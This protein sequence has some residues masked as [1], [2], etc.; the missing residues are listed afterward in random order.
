MKPLAAGG[1]VPEVASEEYEVAVTP[2]AGSVCFHMPRRLGVIVVTTL[3]TVAVAG[4]EITAVV[5]AWLTMVAPV[6]IA[7]PLIPPPTSLAK[8]PAPVAVNV[9]E[10][11]TTSAFA[12]RLLPT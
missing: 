10:P 2:T 5:P 6:G 8:N 11:E 9:V 1:F 12:N 3:E 4:A 7:V